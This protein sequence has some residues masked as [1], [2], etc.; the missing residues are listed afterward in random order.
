MDGWVSM[1]YLSSEE[2]DRGVERMNIFEAREG[3][4]FRLMNLPVLNL[5]RVMKSRAS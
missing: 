5:A 4:L 2:P 3:P 1:M